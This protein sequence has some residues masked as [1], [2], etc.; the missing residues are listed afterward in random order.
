MGKRFLAMLVAVMFATN[1]SAAVLTPEE[2]ALPPEAKGLRIAE[3]LSDDQDGYVDS[4]LTMKMILINKNGDETVREMHTK[5]KE[6]VDG[7]GDMGL[8][9][10]DSP[11]DQK[12]TALLTHSHKDEDDEQ[13]LYLPAL[14]RVKKIAS[15]GKSGSFMGSEFSFEDIGGGGD[16]KD[17]EYKWLRDEVYEGKQC[18]VLQSIPKDKNSGYTKIIA[19]IDKE[20]GRNYK[21]EFYD[22]KN[23][24]LKTMTI[25]GFKKYNGEHDRPAELLMVNHQTG[26]STKMLMSDYEFGV[27]LNEQDFTKNSLKRAR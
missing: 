1:M 24:H 17:Y 3:N 26:K 16:T 12:G 9:V 4:I 19:W 15:S 13:W 2:E 20:S 22:R 27:G 14:K 5:N 7:E 8:I 10:F 23:S 21:T 25:S 6:G 18:F 11:R